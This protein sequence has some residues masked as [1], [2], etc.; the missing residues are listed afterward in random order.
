MRQE[1]TDCIRAGADTEHGG[2]FV[3]G[4]ISTAAC[5]SPHAYRHEP[6]SQKDEQPGPA[7]AC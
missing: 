7:G 6:A 1:M 5:H 2:T 3:Q 4:G